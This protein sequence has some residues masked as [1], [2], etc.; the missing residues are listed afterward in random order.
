MN[1][2]QISELKT[3]IIEKNNVIDS[4]NNVIEKLKE[5]NELSLIKCTALNNNI[6]TLLNWLTNDSLYN[7]D[8]LLQNARIKLINILELFKTKRE[9]YNLNQQISILKSEVVELE[10]EKLYQSFGLYTP[11]YNAM[12]S[13]I[14]KE[15]IKSCRDK[16]K[17]M[18]KG[19]NAATC[20]SSWTINGNIRE[21]TKMINH[22]IKQ[23]LRSFNNE[24]DYLIAKVKYNNICAIKRKIYMSYKS[25]NKLNEI[26]AITISSNYLGLKIEELQLCYEYED[27]K[28]QE[29]E[30]ARMVREEEREQAKLLKE[31]EEERKKIKKE[32]E[33]YITYLRHINEQ[34]EIEQD[35]DRLQFLIDKR[36]TVE[37]NLSDLDTA[38]KD[39]DYREAN[40]KA[41]YVYII[42]NIGAFGENVYK[43]GMTRRLNPQER[44]DELGG[45]SGPFKFDLHAMIF[46]D[47]APALEA[48]LHKA[49]DTKKVNMANNRKEFFNVTLDEIKQVINENYDKTVDFVDTPSAQQYRESLQIK[50]NLNNKNH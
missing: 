35:S 39:I 38:L 22:N 50:A 8:L 46:S 32:Q 9:I 21:G 15:L 48:S 23:I 6:N 29:K 27:K 2:E 33:H 10:D 47:N 7:Y 36:N 13:S 12:S 31:I 28:Q 14:Y 5:E 25:L 19:K 24:C 11:I 16:Q 40:Q 17:Q 18:I 43:I 26:N 42:S 1:N 34:I 37:E 44:I 45:A 20:Y 41:G 3:Q 49:F 30:Y 4:L